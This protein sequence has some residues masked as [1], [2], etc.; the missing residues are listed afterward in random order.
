LTKLPFTNIPSMSSLGAAVTGSAEAG[1]SVVVVVVL[2][3]A[4]GGGSVVVVVVV[5]FTIGAG[6]GAPG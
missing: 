2:G 6:T 3:V 1:P 5:G 4:V